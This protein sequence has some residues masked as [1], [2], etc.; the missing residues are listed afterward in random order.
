ME[1]WFDQIGR[2]GN[3]DDS[4][5]AVCDDGGNGEQDLTKLIEVHSPKEPR[6]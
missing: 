6:F 2:D 5:N 3:N 1:T 4:S